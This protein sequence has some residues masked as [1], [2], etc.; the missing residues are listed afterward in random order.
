[1]ST[2]NNDVV[3]GK[4]QKFQVSMLI[5]DGYENHAH[6]YYSP[7]CGMA[8]KANILQTTVSMAFLKKIK[9]IDLNSAKGYV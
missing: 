6:A 8:K 9:H 4:Q 7:H 1:M 3:E 2:D 5:A